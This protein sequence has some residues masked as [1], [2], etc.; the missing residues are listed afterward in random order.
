MLFQKCTIDD[1]PALQEI[2]RSTYRAT[3]AAQNTEANMNAYLDDA[4]NAEKLK[5]ELLTEASSFYFAYENG[6]LAGYL[7]L[8]ES[9]AQ[10]DVN[11]PS[12]IELERIY[13]IPD[14][15][16]QGVGRFLM[17]RAVTIARERNRTYLWLGVW[18]KNERAL[19]FY[20]KNGFSPM[21]THAFV[22]G[23]D[24]QRD[25]LLRKDL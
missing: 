18:E 3:F 10:T 24:I 21:G 19:K 2:S 8:N 7:K 11:D 4:F 9:G 5:N 17:N 12:S 6:R 14:F 13:V 1:L 23:T 25:Y 15:Q 22:M 20:R 16:G